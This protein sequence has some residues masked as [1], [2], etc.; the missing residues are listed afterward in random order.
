[1]QKKREEEYPSGQ[2]ALDAQRKARREIRRKRRRRQ[3]LAAR[4]VAGALGLVVLCAAGFGLYRLG[5]FCGGARKET[6]PF[7]PCRIRKS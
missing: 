3:V 2:K 7:R 6:G 5:V 4:I 1:M